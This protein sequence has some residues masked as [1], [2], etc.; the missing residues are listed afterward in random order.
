MDKQIIAKDLAAELFASEAAIDEAFAQVG[1]LAHQ[2]S[3]ARRDMGLAAT[4]GDAAFTA[5]GQSL[6]LLAQARGE[7]VR[8]HE[9]LAK[10][11]RKV[12]LE[13]VAF[14]GLEKPD[15]ERRPLPKAEAAAVRRIA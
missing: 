5:V 9:E 7:V 14:G 11:Q 15:H 2:L 1:R 8:A 3:C 10:V 13:E 6:A 4:V 12:G